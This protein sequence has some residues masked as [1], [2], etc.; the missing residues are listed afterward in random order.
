MSAHQRI[1]SLLE[2]YLR[3]AWEHFTFENLKGHDEAS[4]EAC[5]RLRIGF[6]FPNLADADRELLVA[7]FYAKRSCNLSI[8]TASR[9]GPSV[10]PPKDV[11]RHETNF[12]DMKYEVMRAPFFNRLTVVQREILEAR[13]F[14][15]L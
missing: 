3:L 8:K 10:I 5:E 6:L 13:Y 12:M 4:I 15:I 14:T 7:L 9:A 2:E 1:D 11:D